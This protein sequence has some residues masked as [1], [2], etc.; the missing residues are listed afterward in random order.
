MKVI[1]QMLNAIQINKINLWIVMII[2]T[3]INFNLKMK[4]INKYQSR[5]API[6]QLAIYFHLITIKYSNL[7]NRIVT[8]V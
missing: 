7:I 4:L 5:K 1:K 2:I 6:N 8:T 3:I